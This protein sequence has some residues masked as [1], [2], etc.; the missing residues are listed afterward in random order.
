MIKKEFKVP[1]YVRKLEALT[2]RIPSN[3]PMRREIQEEHGRHLAGYKGEQS[4]QYYFNF[5]TS[6]KILHLSSLKIPM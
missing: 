4:L 5:F 6:G 1:L 3:H 2:R